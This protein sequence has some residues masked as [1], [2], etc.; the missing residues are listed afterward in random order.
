M[1]SPTDKLRVSCKHKQLGVPIGIDKFYFGLTRN[2]TSNTQKTCASQWRQPTNLQH[3]EAITTSYTHKPRGQYY[4]RRKSV[5]SRLTEPAA[6]APQ[7]PP[8]RQHARQ[9]QHGPS[10]RPAAAAAA[11]QHRPRTTD[12]TEADGA[13]SPHARPRPRRRCCAAGA[14]QAQC[15]CA[16]AGAGAHARASPTGDSCPVPRRWPGR[17]GLRVAEA[18]AAQ[19]RPY[20]AAAAADSTPHHAAAVNHRSDTAPPMAG[21]QRRLAAQPV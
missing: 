10:A 19:D 5:S 12:N 2:R 13:H 6:T 15:V 9:Q 21:R 8:R 20:P 1:Q 17:R 14:C 16:G 7:H 18:P 11:R 4:T 3:T